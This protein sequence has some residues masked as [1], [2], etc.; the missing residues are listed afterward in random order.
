MDLVFYNAH[1][2]NAD[3]SFSSADAVSVK[4]GSI[5]AVGTSAELL[6]GENSDI[7][8]VNLEG[9]FLYPGF[10]DCHM[11]LLYTEY[12][13]ARLDVGECRTREEVLGRLRAE[14]LR[15]QSS[16][17][18]K[19][20]VA[21]H[22][23]EQHW[24]DCPVVPTRLELD[25][26]TGDIPCYMLRCCEHSA[27]YNTAA[28]QLLGLMEERPGS[29]RDMSFLENGTPSGQ[30]YENDACLGEEMLP[31]PT[32]SEISDF[33]RS[34]TRCCAALG[35]TAVHSDDL[36]TLDDDPEAAMKAYRKAAER[37]DL[38]IRVYQQCR[39]E[40]PKAIT[41]FCT[42][43]P[44]GTRYGRFK[45]VSVKELLDGSL[46]AHSAFLL[47][48]YRND[49]EAPNIA[50][51]TDDEV[52]SMVQAAHRCGYPM[53]VHCI[54]DGAVEQYLK[55]LETAAEPGKHFR[56][57]V[58]HCQIMRLTQLERMARLGVMAYVQPVFV[59]TDAP[60][61]EACVGRELAKQ[62]YNWRKM[63][64]FGIPIAAG[65]DCPVESDDPIANFYYAVTRDGGNGSPWL[66]ENA[67]TRQEALEALT[68]GGAYAAGEETH[69]GSITP[70]KL[71]DFTVLD[72]N[73][74][75]CDARDI[76]ST[77]VLMTVVGGEIS[78]RAE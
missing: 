69:N 27:V 78:Y 66:P 32:E 3:G 10:T 31:A 33:I 11:H 7:P 63:R 38:A 39:L 8:T 73:L 13:K 53:I 1:I 20:I 41:D 16:G 60:V 59:G 30:L 52:L 62:S 2:V 26:V 51:F 23:N 72:R 43:Y 54:G 47:E 49:P 21:A 18:N 42:K 14:A 35:L 68:L 67:L 56:D 50:M 57:G 9:A 64:D 6:P 5:A 29:S 36:L 4:N 25:A 40:S 58:N 45:T 34:G 12:L 71:A 24:Q 76:R 74:L 77:R 17:E 55:A 75:T 65:T 37:G 15:I 70:G 22:F 46:G 48:G 44:L 61:V 19:W 28:L